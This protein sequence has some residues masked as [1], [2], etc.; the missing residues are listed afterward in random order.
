[1]REKKTTNNCIENCQFLSK[2]IELQKASAVMKFWTS[3]QAIHLYENRIVQV[4]TVQIIRTLLPNDIYINI[5]FLENTL[6]ILVQTRN[7]V[8]PPETCELLTSVH[9]CHWRWGVC[10]RR[11]AWS[12]W[13]S[14]GKARHRGHYGPHLQSRAWSL[15]SRKHNLVLTHGMT[16][17]YSKANFI[18]ETKKMSMKI[19]WMGPA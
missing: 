3:H 19:A 11:R 14:P 4:V 8:C 16:K 6:L 5:W 15:Q 10:R 9:L 17:F 7:A 2:G 18:T 12:C 1:M 13:R